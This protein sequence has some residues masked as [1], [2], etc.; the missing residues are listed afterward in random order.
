MVSLSKTWTTTADFDSGVYVNADAS[1]A[2][3]VRKNADGISE[4]S[5]TGTYDSG[6]LGAWKTLTMHF[7]F[8]SLGE[9]H[10]RYRS[11]DFPLQTG[12]P[13]S[14]QVVTTSAT[15]V[16]NVSELPSRRYFQIYVDLWPNAA[17]SHSA[18]ARFLDATITGNTTV[19]VVGTP[20]PIIET[21]GKAGAFA[22][23][24]DQAGIHACEVTGADT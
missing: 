7:A 13:W 8:L 10:Y 4:G 18:N 19:A 20:P 9:A 17:G 6:S 12:D 2:D 22:A 23:C 21:Q 3:E 15:V 5:W 1:V 11:T 14:A 24:A 16:V